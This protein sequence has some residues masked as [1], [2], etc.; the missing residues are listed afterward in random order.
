MAKATGN[1]KKLDVNK[2]GKIS[3]A[4]FSLLKKKKGVA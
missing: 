4:D 3:K 1:R 2:D